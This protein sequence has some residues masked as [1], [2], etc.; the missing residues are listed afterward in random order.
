MPRT[1]SRKM[2]AF[3]FRRETLDALVRISERDDI[4]QTEVIERAVA[5]LAAEE[6]GDSEGIS[7]DARRGEDT[8]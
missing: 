6:T 1:K 4:T 8:V 7:L 5:R 2:A 3:R